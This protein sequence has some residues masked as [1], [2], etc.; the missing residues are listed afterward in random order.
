MEEKQNMNQESIKSLKE[1]RE[2]QV[3][4]NIK[5]HLIFLG[6]IIF[7]NICLIIFIISYKYKIRQISSKS[8]ENSIQITGETNYLSNLENSL[9]HKIVN[10]FAMSFNIYGNVH[11]SF[12]FE[13]SNEVQ[14]VKDTLTSFSL[15]S[16]PFIH[17]TYESNMDGDSSSTILNLIK[18]W[19]NILFII[20]SQTNE[21]FGFFFQES[22][23]PNKKGYFS[24]ET[25]RC[26]LYS[27]IN[28]KA[29]AC[30]DNFSFNYNNLLNIGNGDIIINHNFKTNGG[31]INFP[32]KSIN[33]PETENE[34][35]KLKGKFEIKDI[36]V[37]LVFDLN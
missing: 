26:F 27:F 7:I 6:L 13:H 8:K 30:T 28:K 24:S 12:L 4:T 35:V 33:V 22:V 25:H 37:Y 1:F 19:T 16:K 15:F 18:Y 2:K 36:E 32:F 9:S 11:F 29:Y 20:G 34:F 14:S 10:L 31:E 3:K 5:I 17:L 23:Y 21:K